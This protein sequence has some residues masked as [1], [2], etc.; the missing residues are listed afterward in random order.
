MF[1]DPNCGYCKRF[2]RDLLGVS[3]IT[4][5]LFL[6]PI[7]APDSMV[8]SKAIWCAPDRGKAWLDYM[9]R[10]WPVP[11]HTLRHAA[12]RP[13]R[14]VRQGQAHHRHAHDLLR[15]RRARARR[16]QHGRFREEARGRE[17]ARKGLLEV[18]RYGAVGAAPLGGV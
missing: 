10:D 17:G 16:D 14:G 12:D 6:Y 18:A 2:E 13:Q 11:R 1:A 5:Y 4:V 9:V 7:L 3:D 8:K 15:G